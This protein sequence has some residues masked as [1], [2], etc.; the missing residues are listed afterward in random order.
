[1]E[2]GHSKQ[3]CATPQGDQLIGFLPHPVCLLHLHHNFLETLLEFSVALGTNG[4]LMI[5]LWKEQTPLERKLSWNFPATNTFFP[6]LA[7][8]L[9]EGR[10]YRK[11]P[12]E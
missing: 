3:P 6:N 10:M 7:A 1:M 8:G 11:S 12:L 5:S 9:H 4:Y 2:P